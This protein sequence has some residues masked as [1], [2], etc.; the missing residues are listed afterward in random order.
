MT[1]GS[2]AW[3][4]LIGGMSA[5]A[6]TAGSVPFEC[7]SDD[8]CVRGEEVGRCELTGYCSF[9]DEECDSGW[10]YA[11]L[12]RGELAEQCVVQCVL[13]LSLGAEHSC[14]VLATGEVRCWG[15]GADGRLGDGIDGAATPNPVSV[16]GSLPPMGS[17]TAGGGHTC[18]LAD[19]DGTVWCWGD[20][21]ALQLG[22]QGVGP[23]PVQVTALEGF[24]VPVTQITA[25]GGHTCARSSVGSGCWGANHEGQLGTGTVGAAAEP[26]PVPFESGFI[27]LAAGDLHTCGRTMAGTVHCWGDN[28]ALQ[29]GAPDSVD[30][31]L[32]PERVQTPARAASMELGLLHGC[33]VTSNET[34]ECWGN[35]LLAGQLGRPQTLGG[36]RTPV[37][38]SLP[39][40]VVQV[41]VGLTHSCALDTEGRAW[42]WGGNEFGQ[43]GPNQSESPFEPTP[44]V[45]ELPGGIAEIA[46]GGL[47]TC[48]RTE[49]DAV[50]C[51]G[52]NEFGQL[53]NGETDADGTGSP[54]STVTEAL[55]CD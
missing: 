7:S 48:A 36:S 9:A 3:L 27:E 44:A 28:S 13:G 12:A 42:C 10:R 38:I 37:P 52:A 14:A 29:V 15:H 51:W 34:V 17:V 20:D 18:A 19:D 55:R 21:E 26:T 25:G 30:P 2:P 6:C 41:S 33:M 47:H 1:R 54:D 24:G 53:G 43:H 49:R 32:A 5:S 35:N 40:P 8:Q 45:V 50:Y 4:L 16:G 23:E 11:E 46:A 39:A 31:V 22:R